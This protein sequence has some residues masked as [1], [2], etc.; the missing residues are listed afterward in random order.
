MIFASVMMNLYPIRYLH[1]GRFMGR[2]PWFAR[3][4]AVLLLTVFTPYFGYTAFLYLFL[5]LLSPLITWRIHPEV[6]AKES[7]KSQ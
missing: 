2:H 7:K 1:L 6:A 4:S 3:S 5:Y